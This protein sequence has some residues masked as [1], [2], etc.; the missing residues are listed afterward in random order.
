MPNIKLVEVFSSLF[1]ELIIFW[2]KIWPTVK[3]E[4]DD[5]IQKELFQTSKKSIK[6]FKIKANIIYKH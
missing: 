5:K 1:V 3:K 4:I 6:Y 2:L